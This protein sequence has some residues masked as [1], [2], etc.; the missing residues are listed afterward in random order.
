MERTSFSATVRALCFALSI[1]SVVTAICGID[2]FFVRLGA[3]DSD[4]AEDP[5]RTQMGSGCNGVFEQSSSVDTLRCQA[6][7]YET[8]NQP[9]QIVATT[10]LVLLID[11][12]HLLSRLGIH[13]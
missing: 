6:K 8:H 10:V 12:G 3:S 13:N 1:P 9:T 11:F 7:W 5:E 2:A 4:Y